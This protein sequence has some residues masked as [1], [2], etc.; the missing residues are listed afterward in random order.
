MVDNAAFTITDAKPCA[1]VVTLSKEYNAKLTKLLG[2][3]FK[4]SVYCNKYKVIPNKTYNQD[5]KRIT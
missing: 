2:E 5:D 4:R 3:G 1:P